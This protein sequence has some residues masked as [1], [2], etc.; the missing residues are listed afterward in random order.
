MR[1]SGVRLK[2]VFMMRLPLAVEVTK[3][4]RVFKLNLNDYRNTNYH[5]LNTAKK[6][7]SNKIGAALK[8]RCPQ[9]K[10]PIKITYVIMRS[11]NILY[12]VG[13]VGSILDKFFC[14]SLQDAK[15]IKDDNFK[16]IPNVEFLHGVTNANEPH[17]MVYIQELKEHRN[18]YG[19]STSY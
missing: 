10:T 15:R 14:D 3:K 18:Y 4:G 17:C 7:F 8:A 19:K 16:F 6:N 11:N 9:L 5:I 1:E 13:N 12:D 2:S